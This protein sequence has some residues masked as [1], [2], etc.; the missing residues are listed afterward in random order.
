MYKLTTEQRA[1][2]RSEAKETYVQAGPG[3]G[4]TLVLAERVNWLMEQGTDPKRI[5]ALTF[6][7]RAAQEL[8]ERLVRVVAEPGF[9][10]PPPPI[11]SGTFHA[12][13]LGI[14]EQ[15]GTELGYSSGLT[16]LDAVEAEDVF[17]QI[18]TELD[19]R[20]KSGRWKAK[21]KLRDVLAARD[22]FYQTGLFAC[23]VEIERLILL[24]HERLF[25]LNSL[26]FG[27]ILTQ[28]RHLLL[29]DGKAK[30][31][32]ATAFDHVLIDE[33]QDCDELQYSLHFH[34]SPPASLFMVGDQRQCIYGWRGAKPE[35]LTGLRPG[36]VLLNLT[37][38]Y[39]CTDE[40]LRPANAL[41]DKHQPMKSAR[42]GLAPAEAP[43]VALMT[44]RSR[45]VS[46]AVNRL[47]HVD[48][49]EWPDIAVLCRTHAECKRLAAVF[50]EAR[51]PYH[52]VGSG[53]DPC[54]GP[55]YRDVYAA[56]RLTANMRD[57]L[58]FG[59]VA[60]YL[61]LTPEA[62]ASLRRIAVDERCTRF[63]AA[64]RHHSNNAVL[65]AIARHEGDADLCLFL[66]KLIPA[67]A[68]PLDG[69]GMA[70]DLEVVGD[71]QQAWNFWHAWQRGRTISSAL[72]WFAM[73]DT[74]EDQVEGEDE[75]TISTI[76]AAKGLEWPAVVVPN[77][78]EGSLPTSR[79]IR[80]GSVDEERRVLYVAMTRAFDSLTLHYRRRQ[81]QSEKGT[82]REPSRFLQDCG[83]LPVEALP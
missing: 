13:A 50:T 53:F 75:V 59:R 43:E 73:R 30:E 9:V 60:R 64:G 32:A 7:R 71:L 37:D 78:T 61:D 47:H 27:L 36:A 62:L 2:V 55:I 44:G 79:S 15:F 1:A 49:F 80:G 25:S 12:V 46:S 10:P 20:G 70:G 6:T 83:L 35:M 24:Y 38:S 40:I 77:L 16:V 54:K 74:H 18:A 14:L 29:R 19:M 63:E 34:F 68:E 41:M 4:K 52:R 28:T 69:T 39:R 31:W 5:L 26:D 72:S 3:S 67:M 8:Q 51:V 11:V 21:F 48:K 58:A 33:A 42:R 23:D 22:H 45:D 56:L 65:T 81:D 57:D 76:H 17:D 82:K 66:E